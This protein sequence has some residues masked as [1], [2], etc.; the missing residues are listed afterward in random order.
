MAAFVLVEN[1][2]R[3]IPHIHP[4]SGGISTLKN[5]RFIKLAGNA[6]N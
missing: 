5:K 3:N 1:H 2:S 6:L 4:P